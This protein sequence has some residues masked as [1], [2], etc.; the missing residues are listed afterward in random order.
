MLKNNH[1]SK[2]ALAKVIFVLPFIALLL[3]LNCKNKQEEPEV[4][5]YNITL[6]N[7]ESESDEEVTYEVQITEGENQG[8]IFTVKKGTKESEYSDAKLT[9]CEENMKKIVDDN[10]N[11]PEGFTFTLCEDE[12]IHKQVEQMPEF[13]GGMKELGNFIK[14]KLKYPV[15][16]AEDSIQGTSVIQFA[17]MKDG[18]VDKV[19]VH[20]SSNPILDKEAVRVIK[21]LPKWNPGKIAGKPVNSYYIIPVVFSLQ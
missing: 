13:P 3:M 1:Y 6:E 8:K 18:S 16:A 9:K 2:W 20:T 21:M 10:P 17:V 14:G 7:I 5:E 19:T 11:F 12:E 4:V 15:K